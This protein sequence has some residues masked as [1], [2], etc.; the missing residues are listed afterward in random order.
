V[1]AM[2]Y[3]LVLK[4]EFLPFATAWMNLQNVKLNGISQ[5]QKEK[6]YMVSLTFE[7]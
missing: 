5:T 7:T 3:Y 4:K 6:Y 2:E 1:C